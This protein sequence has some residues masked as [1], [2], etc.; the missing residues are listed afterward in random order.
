MAQAMKVEEQTNQLLAAVAPE[1]F[2]FLAPHLELVALTRGQVLYE[3]GDVIHYAY[4]PHRAVISLV[5]VLNDGRTVEV[6]V[7]GRGAVMGLLSASTTRESFGRY[8]VQ[9]SGSASRIPVD[10]LEEVRN[11]RPKLRQLIA[12]YGKVLLAHTF[13]LLTCNAVHPVEARCCRWILMLHLH[14]GQDTLPLTHEFLAEML[15][16]QRSTVSAVTKTLQTAGLIRQNRGSITVT[17]WTGLEART[18]E[19]YGRILHIYRRLLRPTPDLPQ[20][21]SQP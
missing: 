16:V 5:N 11:A 19:C 14:L 6:G 20:D 4:F 1:D 2:A 8:V 15:G 3:P 7:F 21:R 12:G 10:R 13:Q 17:D 9:M 18:C